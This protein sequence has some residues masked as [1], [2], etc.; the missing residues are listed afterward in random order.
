[1]NTLCFALFLQPIYKEFIDGLAAVQCR[2]Q[3]EAKVAQ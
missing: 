3:D 1:M 2:Y